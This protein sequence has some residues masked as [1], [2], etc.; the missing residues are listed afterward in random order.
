[1]FREAQTIKT[2]S[3]FDSSRSPVL[4]SCAWPSGKLSCVQQHLLRQFLAG[5]LSARALCLAL[6]HI[7]QNIRITTVYNM[8][9]QVDGGCR[10]NGTPHSVGAAACCA[11][12]EDGSPGMA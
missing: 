4:V 7:R 2:D 5:I 10:G 11:L 12:Q 6:T 8:Q 1:M 9:F 3:W